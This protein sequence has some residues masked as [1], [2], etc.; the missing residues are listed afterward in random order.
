VPDYAVRRISEMATRYGSSFKLAR[1]E[2][3]VTAF[4]MQVI[5][6]PPHA[7]RH[8]EHDHRGDRQEEVYV[9][10]AGSG[11]IELDG[12]RLPLEEDTLVAVG[13]AVRRRISTGPRGLRLLALG[14]V[15]GEPYD[16]PELSKPETL[17][18]AGG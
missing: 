16:P 12:E 11:T 4:G 10:L 8:P 14:G 7:N 15:P 2:L 3:G 1:A 18:F 6:F 13:P 9:V 17:P 5:D